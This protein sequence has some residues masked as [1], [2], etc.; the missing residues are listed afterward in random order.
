MTKR[1]ERKAAS[2]LTPEDIEDYRRWWEERHPDAAEAD[3]ARRFEL[4]RKEW[5]E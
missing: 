4:V 5:M 1:R 3:N 2:V